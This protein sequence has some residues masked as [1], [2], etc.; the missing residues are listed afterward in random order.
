MGLFSSL[1]KSWKKSGNLQKLQNRI[2]SASGSFDT[3]DEEHLMNTYFKEICLQDE[4]VA[5]II[6]K[7]ELSKD[8]LYQYYINLS[9]AGLGQWIKGHYVPL[10]TIAYY[11]PLLYLVESK[12][13]NVPWGTI[14]GNILYYWEGSIKQR[15][16]LSMLK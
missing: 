14:V 1:K 10:S 9:A 12:K 8:D 3:E 11:E 5:S 7:Y 2:V 15:E 13:R 6:R 16:L 4:G